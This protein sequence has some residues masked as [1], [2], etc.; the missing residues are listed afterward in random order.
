VVPAD[1]EWIVQRRIAMGMPPTEPA[2]LVL[3]NAPTR[4]D[5]AAP[6]SLAEKHIIVVALPRHLTHVVQPI[7]VCWARSFKTS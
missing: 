1:A 5:L 6:Q 2:I 7:D 3:D 4:G